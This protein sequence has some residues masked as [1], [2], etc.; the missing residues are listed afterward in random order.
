MK[1][2]FLLLA[3]LC[4]CLTGWAQSDTTAKST[5]APPD[6]GDTIHVGNLLIVKSGREYDDDSTYRLHRRHND[7]STYRPSNISTN[8]CILDLGFSNF[9]DKTDYGSASAQ[10]FAPGATGD[11][12]H[13][14]TIKSVN[15]NIWLFM[16]RLNLIKHVVNLKYGL[17]IELNNYRYTE[18]I[19]Y[20]TNP[21]RVIMDT[22]SYSKN[23][24][25]AD[26]F[27]I[28]FM[29]NFNFTPGRRNGFGLSLGASA[30]Y[31][32]SSRQKVKSGVTGKRKTFDD[33]DMEPWK[34]SWIGELQLGPVRLYGS[35]AT[36]SMFRN[37]LDQTPYT[38][39]IRF[40]NW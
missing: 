16:Q 5:A 20:L 19:K 22:I 13:L 32:Y 39:G 3:A 1:G 11:W 36:K 21:T 25:A 31:K 9:S 29:L 14:R 12:F 23:K 17:G 34:I 7:H 35:L 10:H 30:G 15:V 37:G 40:S 2:Q 27:T 18:N 4:L 38:V 28:P 24:L 8:W 6:A 33:F 26:Y